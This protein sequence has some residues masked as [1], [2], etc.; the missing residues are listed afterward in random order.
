MTEAK[1]ARKPRALAGLGR[2]WATVLAAV[3][4]VG[5]SGMIGA[6]HAG[7]PRL[8][9]RRAAVESTLAHAGYCQRLG[10]YYWEIGDASGVLMHG[11]QGQRI[12]ANKTVR[13]A[14]ASKWVF[15]AY[16]VERNVQYILDAKKRSAHATKFKIASSILCSTN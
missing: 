15:G 10:D 16:V 14:S 8:A 1:R 7:E 2:R 5:C 4:A 12:G 6:V 3:G 13:L 11:Q 9:M